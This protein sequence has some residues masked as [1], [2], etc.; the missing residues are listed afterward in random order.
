MF[1]NLSVTFDLRDCKNI[2][3]WYERCF[4][5]KQPTQRDINTVTKIK[6]YAISESEETSRRKKLFSGK[7]ELD[8]D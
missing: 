4:K 7:P 2:L 5:K 6:A 3:L 1:R 8:D